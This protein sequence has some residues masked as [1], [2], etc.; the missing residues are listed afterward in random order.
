MTS[1]TKTNDEICDSSQLTTPFSALPNYPRGYSHSGS[2][3]T[4]VHSGTATR[5]EVPA[6]PGLNAFKKEI[7]IQLGISPELSVRSNDG[8]LR[9]A[10]QKYK[11]YL[12]ACKTYEEKIIDKSWVGNK[13]TGSD[14]IQ[15]F[16]S[17]SYF[18]SHY[19]KHFSKISNYP[20]MVDW[21]E[22]GPNAPADED[23]W[24]EVKGSYNFKDL[25]AYIEE[26]EKMMKRTKRKGKGKGKSDKGD[27]KD[28]GGSKKVGEKKKN[29]K[30]VN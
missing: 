24:A 21:L 25:G 13:L 11:A 8:G 4:S 10:Y 15:L 16:I 17:K 28:E 18:H 2:R 5:A 29:K 23:I 12:Q 3:S 27:D 7:L 19:K 1:S 26:Q 30:Q 9:P 14:I 6:E 22:G 20:Q